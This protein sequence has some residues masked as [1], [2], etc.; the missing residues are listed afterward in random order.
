MLRWLLATLVAAVLLVSVL[1]YRETLDVAETMDGLRPGV[2]Q[3]T[4]TTW[5]DA[6]TGEQRTVRTHRRPGQSLTAWY[7]EHDAAV[8]ARKGR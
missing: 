6:A 4:E 1:N 5:T 7:Q 2:Y 8:A 3:Y